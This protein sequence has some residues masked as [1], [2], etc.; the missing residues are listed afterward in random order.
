MAWKAEVIADNSGKWAG[1][2]LVFESKGD[3]LGYVNDLAIRWTAVR[4]T[5]VVETSEEVNRPDTSNL[6]TRE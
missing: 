3:A 2:G 1:N 6:V 4:E 5:R